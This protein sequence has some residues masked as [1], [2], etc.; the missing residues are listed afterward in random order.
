MEDI[1]QDSGRA[2]AESRIIRKDARHKRIM[3]V[4]RRRRRR[5]D[6]KLL[7]NT[8]FHLLGRLVGECH[9]QD[10]PICIPVLVLQKK[11]YI[12]LCQVIGLA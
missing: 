10:M 12:C 2:S 11:T 4:R 6:M 5:K 9:S 3:I 1:P 8:A 7:E